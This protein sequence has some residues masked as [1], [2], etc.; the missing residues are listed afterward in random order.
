MMKKTKGFN[1]DEISQKQRYCPRCKGKH[2]IHDPDKCE[3]YCNTCGLVLQGNPS[4]LYTNNQK[5]HY[6]WGLIL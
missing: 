2:I 6:P 5:T 4:S 1:E 3:V